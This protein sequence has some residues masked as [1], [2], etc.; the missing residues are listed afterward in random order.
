M[1]IFFSACQQGANHQRSLAD[2]TSRCE[3]SAVCFGKITF[4]GL[5]GMLCVSSVFRHF[6]LTKKKRKNVFG[7]KKLHTDIS[8]LSHSWY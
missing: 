1:F 2:K 5:T 7:K 3:V 4:F 8:G 6:V